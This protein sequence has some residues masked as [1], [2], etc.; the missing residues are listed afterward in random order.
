MTLGKRP[1]SRRIS[2]GRKERKM[3][4]SAVEDWLSGHESEM[5]SADFQFM[6]RLKKKTLEWSNQ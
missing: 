5:G 4:V 2:F 1:K 6:E 3:L